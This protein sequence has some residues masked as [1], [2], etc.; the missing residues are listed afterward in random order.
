MRLTQEQRQERTDEAFQKHEEWA[1]FRPT[2]H[3]PLPELPARATRNTAHEAY[4]N[5]ILGP[6]MVQEDEREL[7]GLPPR[8]SLI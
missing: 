1:R 6:L 5:P 4:S 8:F 2:D 7:E 3:A